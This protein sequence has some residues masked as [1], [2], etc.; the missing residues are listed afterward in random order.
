ME[1]LRPHRRIAKTKDL[2]VGHGYILL[3]LDMEANYDQTSGSQYFTNRLV[4][5]T[6]PSIG[7]F[8]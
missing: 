5:F 3:I 6:K 4:K 8:T 1:K 7:T 2:E